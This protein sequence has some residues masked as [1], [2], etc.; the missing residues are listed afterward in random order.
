MSNPF[1]NEKLKKKPAEQKDKKRQSGDPL[2]KEKLEQEIENLEELEEEGDAELCEELLEVKTELKESHDKLLLAHAE[3]E[4]VRRRAQKD[5]ASAHKYALEKF[6][7]DLLPVLDNF[8]HA[9]I[10]SQKVN[11]DKAMIEGIELTQQSLLKVLENHGVKQINPLNEMFD[12][13]YHEAVSMV[14]NPEVKPNTI[15]DVFQK[16]YELNGRL[17]RPA[18]VVVS[19]A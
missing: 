13:Q 12:P 16:G 1:K 4:N 2:L 6:V 3:L 5:I 19:K 7:K 15:L 9:L 17:V 8:D 11:M 10:N 18:R 14:Q